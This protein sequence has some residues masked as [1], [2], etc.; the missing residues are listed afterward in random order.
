M[1]II[2]RM[3]VSVI[4]TAL[5]MG[6]G[7]LEPGL[8][9]FD[10]PED[11]VRM[12][13]VEAENTVEKM[14]Q[15]ENVPPSLSDDF[16]ERYLDMGSFEELKQRTLDGIQIT[17][18][19]SDM[20]EAEIKLWEQIVRNADFNQYTTSDLE[21]RKAELLGI[22]DSLAK[23]HD[24]TTEEFLRNGDFGIDLQS[25]EGFLE[26]QAEKYASEFEK[27]KAEGLPDISERTDFY[28]HSAN[29]KSSDSTYADKNDVVSS[30]ED[31]RP[32]ADV[33]DDSSNTE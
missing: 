32:Y 33:T 10:L 14:A 23:E 26:R 11:Y 3:A 22:L 2:K 24:M 15:K 28:E 13:A 16:M 19:L 5:F 4:C 27:K 21:R 9:E 25:A 20:S 1:Y 12:A 6:C 30:I 7:Y 29:S 8:K 31:G 18:D 17:N